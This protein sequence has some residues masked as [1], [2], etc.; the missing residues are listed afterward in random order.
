VNLYLHWRLLQRIFLSARKSGS[1]VVGSVWNTLMTKP[2]PP[3]KPF[4]PKRIPL[5]VAMRLMKEAQ[6]KKK[7]EDEEKPRKRLICE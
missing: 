7:K 3:P 1:A 6:E 2:K 4:T 5:E